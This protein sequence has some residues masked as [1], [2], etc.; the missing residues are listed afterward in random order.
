MGLTGNIGCGKS[1]VAGLLGDLGAGVID[2]DQVAHA[3]MA[4][5]GPVYDSLVR[6][7]GTG[8]VTPDGAIDR[9][10]LG[11]IVFAD[12]AALRRLDAL[13]HPAT[14][15]AIREMIATSSAPVVVVEAIKLIEAGTHR[16][17]DSVWVV[18]CTREQQVQRLTTRRGLSRAEAERRID[19]QPPID[20][21]LRYATVVIDNS[22]TVEE[23]RQEV[24]AAWHR[25]GL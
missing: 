4:P 18:R 19:A 6:E 14:S 13:V 5:P 2:A 12:P 21:K 16:L 3:V 1:T 10:A 15:A 20:D 23:T 17:C 7:F 11:Q 25:L 9:H 24:V 8:I 22:G